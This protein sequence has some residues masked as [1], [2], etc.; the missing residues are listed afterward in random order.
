MAASPAPPGPDPLAELVSRSKARGAC[1]SRGVPIGFPTPWAFTL[2]VPAREKHCAPSLRALGFQA[3][4]AGGV[5]FVSRGGPGGARGPR[6]AEGV[7]ASACHVAGNYP[8]AGF[9][10]QWRLE[11]VLVEESLEALGRLGS[12]V[13]ASLAV[14]VT[15][16]A[17]F[18]RKRRAGQRGSL[19]P[20]DDSGRA[21]LAGD[22]DARELEEQVDRQARAQKAGE[23]TPAVERAAGLRAFRL[24]PRRVELLEGGPAWPG[25]PRKYEWVRKAGSSRWG[26]PRRALPYSVP[27]GGG[28]GGLLARPHLVR[29]ALAVYAVLVTA[30]LLAALACMAR[31]AAPPWAGLRL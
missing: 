28:E 3:V 16:C 26:P 25:G 27:G 31:K 9:E 21:L 2:A 1:D 29:D 14:Q 22:G 13:Q 12:P 6:D 11:G 17:A 15:A 19:A 10:E 20:E 5:W 30:V 23:V 18:E 4:T 7:E 24:V 8:G